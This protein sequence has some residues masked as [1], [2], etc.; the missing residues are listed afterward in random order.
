[1]AMT[2]RRVQPKILSAFLRP[3]TR[4]EF[5][6]HS[7]IHSFCIF[8]TLE[9]LLSKQAALVTEV[10]AS[11]WSCAGVLQILQELAEGMCV[12]N[13]MLVHRDCCFL[14]NSETV[15]QPTVLCPAEKSQINSYCPLVTPKCWEQIKTGYSEQIFSWWYFRCFISFVNI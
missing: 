9:A 11:P 8:E 14:Y 6:L 15:I 10:G 2:V 13:V 1:M 4:I 5:L 7:Q 12:P 3:K